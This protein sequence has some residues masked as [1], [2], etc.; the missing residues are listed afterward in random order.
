MAPYLSSINSGQVS[1]L[2]NELVQ[3]IVK[4][5]IIYDQSHK[6]VLFTYPEHS[7]AIVNVFNINGKLVY[8][9]TFNADAKTSAMQW[10]FTNA[11]GA[12]LAK[13][14]YHVGM[15]VKRVNES[16]TVVNQTLMHY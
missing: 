5:A 10:N 6:S 7:T 15:T 9:N 13:G 8:S 3:K 11:H 4:A 2:D 1:S 16:P 14:I 12:A